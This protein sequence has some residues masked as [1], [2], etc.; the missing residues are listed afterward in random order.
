MTAH[1]VGRRRAARTQPQR[2]WTANNLVGAR[3]GL[4]TRAS[5]DHEDTKTSV[6]AQAGFGER[7]GN[8]NGCVIPE[9]GRYTDNDK[10]ASWYA[11]KVRDDFERLLR[12]IAAGKLDLVWFWT[13][14]R[15]QRDLSAYVKL[16]DLCRM[17]G[18]GLVIKNRLYDLSDPSDL[19]SL[20][21]DAVNGEV[22]S[23][24]ISQNVRLGMELAATLGKPHGPLTYGYKRVYDERGKY[25]RQVPDRTLREAT[26]TDGESYWYSP[27]AVVKEIIT[28]VSKGRPIAQIGRTLEERGIPAPK[29]GS[30]WSRSVLTSIAKNPAY[31][32][33]RVYQ[34]ELIEHEKPCWPTVLVDGDE[35][36]SQDWDKA[37][38]VFYA[39]Q[40]VLKNPDR[41]TTKPGKG[42]HLLSYLGEFRCVCGEHLQADY[43]QR[44]SGKVRNYRCLNRCSSVPADEL[45]SFIR[46][47]VDGYLA[48][49]DV[50]KCINEAQSDDSDVV[51]ARAEVNAIQAEIRENK[52]ARKAG[53]LDLSEYLEFKTALSE[54]LSAAE[55]RAD[56]AAT[57]PVLRAAQVEWN[58][59]P[60]A[61][62]VVAEVIAVTLKPVGKGRRNVPIDE[63]M[64]WKWLIGPDADTN[65]E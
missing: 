52:E 5:D 56:A 32:G 51:A 35:I 60:V 39:A 46:A 62:Q 37:R 36:D 17:M 1:T 4:Y 6:T 7:W 11:T 10:S 13:V 12:D 54:R 28:L 20:G 65:T 8:Q 2:A 57:S 21:M 26:G 3:L 38:E 59:I 61:R 55:A 19:R 64:D 25:V 50:R 23:V 53:K 40:N 30:K 63:R 45:D 44:K 33:K 43:D 27:A 29:G 58:N 42:V 24:E 16:R 15:S 18:V 31:I 41:K 49:E 9:Y 34:G 14:N 22:Q 47:M 48:R